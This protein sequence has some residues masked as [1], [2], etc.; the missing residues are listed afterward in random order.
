MAAEPRR[1]NVLL[2]LT[3][4]QGWGDVRSHGN[5]KIDT[6]V[7]DRLA[8]EGARFDRFFV[9]PL[10]APTRASILTGRYHLRPGV[11][12]VTQG[13]EI[14]RADEITIAEAFRAAGYATGCF[15]KWHNG[16]HYPHHPIGQ[17]FQ[18]F[19]GFCAGHWNNYFDTRLEH[20]GEPIQTKGY[21]TDVLA[22][23]AMDFIREHRCDPFLCYVPFNAPHTPYQVP[24]PYF[25]K[26]KERG[27]NDADACIY[28]MV[29]KVDENIGRLLA[30]LDELQLAND[31]I[32]I[33]LTDNGPNGQRYNGDMRGI[34]GSV[35]EGG[36]RVPCFIRWPGQITPGTVVREMGAHIDLFSTLADLCG[37]PMPETKPLDG[38][39]L[40]SLL[41]GQATDWPERAIFTH[42][43][44]GNQMNPLCGSLRTPRYRLTVESPTYQLFDLVNDPSETTDLAQREPEVY[45]KLA[46]EYERIYR[47]ATSEGFERPRVQVGHAAFPRVEVCAPLAYLSGG[48]EFKGKHG[49]AND[50]ITNWTTTEDEVRWDL[51]VVSPGL[52]RVTLL[53]TCP[54]EDVGSRLQI[55]VG[56]HV[57]ETMLVDAHDPEP[58]PSPDRVPRKEAYEKI[59]EPLG[60][61]PVEFA[62]GDQSLVVRAV[63]IPGQQV[64]DLKAVILRPAQPV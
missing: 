35:H 2:I 19:I 5:E 43:T 28:G 50:W 39:S 15:G 1:P 20:N 38:T 60:F 7:M 45:A 31:T 11:W 27:L 33:F 9:S 52:Y 30:L 22:D 48:L 25:D 29:E 58:I 57:T 47:D 6:P 13:R 10:C 49:W 12:G 55:R 46:A 24:D 63:D 26:Y 40:K 64:M 18:E 62:A 14:L 59:W 56:T 17:G 54:E 36:V 4:D 41:L 8:G 37:V 42:S 53:Y 44:K 32:V 23:A 34:K 3:D 51:H 16:E 61:P 21:I